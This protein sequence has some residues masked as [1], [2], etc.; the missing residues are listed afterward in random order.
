MTVT[1]E[2]KRLLLEGRSPREIAEM[3]YNY[4]TV[5]VVKEKLERESKRSALV[6]VAAELMHRKKGALEYCTGG[7]SNASY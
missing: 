1:E 3:G 5:R 7:P 4:N 6:Q 2:I